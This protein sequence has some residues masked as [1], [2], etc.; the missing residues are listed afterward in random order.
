MIDNPCFFY[1]NN[2]QKILRKLIEIDFD[3]TIESWEHDIVETF[4]YNQLKLQEILECA[5]CFDIVDGPLNCPFCC[6]IFCDKC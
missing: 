2:N 1:N 6:N 5:I 3:D 4:N